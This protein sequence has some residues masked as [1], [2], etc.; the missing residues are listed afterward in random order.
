MFVFLIRRYILFYC[1][2]PK[3]RRM[4]PFLLKKSETRDIFFMSQTLVLSI[5][6]AA[7]NSTRFIP[8]LHYTS[9]LFLVVCS[10]LYFAFMF[11]SHLAVETSFKSQDF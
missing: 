7:V 8:F 3:F 1:I 9:H 5:N 6:L 11:Y 2:K 10:D 4:R